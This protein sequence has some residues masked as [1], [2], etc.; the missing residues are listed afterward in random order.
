MDFWTKLAQN[1]LKQKK[2]ENHHR[3]LQIRNSLG[4]KFQFK[5]II[6]N[7]W[8]KLTQKGY[9]RSKKELKKSPSDSTYSN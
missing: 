2:K 5:L 9:F 8:T 3:V 7:F 4:T 1:G 6:L